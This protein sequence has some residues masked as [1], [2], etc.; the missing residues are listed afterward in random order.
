MKYFNLSI[1]VKKYASMDIAIIGYGKMGKA[2][3]ELA[4]RRGH[5]ILC[6][7]S[8]E[9]LQ[10]FHPK[11][12]QWADVAI[13]FSTPD[14]AFGNIEA[15]L[16]AGVPVVCGTTGWI[17]RIADV[18]NL[19]HQKNG[20]FLYASN[21]SIGVNLF[22]DLN[23]KLARMM[24]GYDM[25]DV[26][27]TETHHTQKLDKPSGTS[28]TLANDIVSELH[29]KKK[30]TISPNVEPNSDEIGITSIRQ[31]PAPGMHEVRYVSEIDEIRLVHEAHSRKGFASG[32]L[33]AAEWIMGKKGVFSMQ[34]VLQIDSDS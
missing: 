8:S 7:I 32:A 6:R 4:V 28:I 15:C 24:R 25:Y 33:L 22:F 3:E 31:D 26:A 11:V 10:E 18:E 27:I 34:D 19:V 21:F 13:E 30:W 9:N 5:T 12:L 1:F 16:D 2:I 20:A 29:R 23:R 17:S 14:S